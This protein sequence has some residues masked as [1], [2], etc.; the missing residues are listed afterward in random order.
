MDIKKATR[1]LFYALFTVLGASLLALVIDILYRYD[2]L[3]KSLLTIGISVII[4]GLAKLGFWA[5]T[6]DRTASTIS[7]FPVPAK[8]DN[9]ND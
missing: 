1:I 2:M 6:P 7:D 3:W 5:F 8:K 9:T 4:I